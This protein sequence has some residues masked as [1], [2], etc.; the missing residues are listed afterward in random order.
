MQLG[1]VFL[2]PGHPFAPMEPKS[3]AYPFDDQE[4]GFQIK[5][6]GVRIVAHIV[7]GKVILYNRR[8]RERTEQYPEIVHA[9][10]S[11]SW[12]QDMILDGEMVSLVEGKPDFPALLRRDQARR[13][14]SIKLLRAKIPVT[15]ILFDLLY[16]GKS[17]KSLSFQ[18][19]EQSLRTNVFMQEPVVITD[20]FWG[21]GKQ[22]F[23]VVKD[24]GLEGMVAKRLTSPY[25]I[26][27][28]SNQWLKIKSWRLFQ[29]VVGGYTQSREKNI[30]ALLLGRWENGQ[31]IYVGKVAVALAQ[32]EKEILAAGLKKLARSTSSFL[33]T[34]NIKGVHFYWVEPVLPVQVEYLDWTEEGY[35]R[36]P[37]LKGF[38]L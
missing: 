7:K 37:V 22:V 1:G 12:P 15:Y 18:E 29:G 11:Y 2:Q 24:Q 32:R 34:P 35:L 9:L 21:C 36:Q 14:D 30:G 19:R 28:A 13:K 17:L 26:G 16:C 31:L 25:I 10:E 38:G 27:K 8:L 33:Y 20:T 4:Y 3:F 6:D 5:W 23:A